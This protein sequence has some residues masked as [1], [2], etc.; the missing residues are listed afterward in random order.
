MSTTK[1]HPAPIRA[2]VK[3]V[4]IMLLIF[5]PLTEDALEG[6]YQPIPKGVFLM[7]QPGEVASLW[8]ARVRRQN[9]VNEFCRLLP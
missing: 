5:S 2:F 3:S 6:P 1:R 4:E 7:L 9:A 8:K